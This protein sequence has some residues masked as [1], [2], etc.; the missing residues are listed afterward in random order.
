MGDVQGGNVQVKPVKSAIR[1]RASIFEK[2]STGGFHT[3]KIIQDQTEVN[4]PHSNSIS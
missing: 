3:Q 1:E 4:S 2:K